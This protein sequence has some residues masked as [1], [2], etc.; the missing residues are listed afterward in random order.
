MII[1]VERPMK[2]YI[3]LIVLYVFLFSES[4]T[5]QN[6]GDQISTVEYIEI[7]KEVAIKE[8]HKSKIPASITLAQGILES[9]KGNSDLAKKAN[10]HFGIKCHKEWRGKTFHMDD[11]EK[12]ECFRKYNNAEESYVDHSYFLTTRERYA[13]LFE[14]D[15]ADYKR[16]AH[17]LK[18]AGY[19]TNPKY[20]HIL[21]RIIEENHL[22]MF[23][24][25]Y[26]GKHV[27]TDAKKDTG[28][29]KTEVFSRDPDEFKPILIAKGNRKIYL[30][31]GIKFIQAGKG[32]D[33]RK[34]ADD[35]E[36]LDW[37]IAR[38]N[39][40]KKGDRLKE[41]ETVYIQ[42]KKKKGSKA[43]HLVRPHET[44]HFIS[45]M[46]GIKLKHLYK[47]NNMPYGSSP[48]VGQKLWLRKKK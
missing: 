37:Q 40:M 16:W 43:Y 38:Y 29:E 2:Y 18:K 1:A 48:R 41:K 11:D 45:Q 20:A 13:E 12:N 26:D 39:D 44:M 7:Y 36:M 47:K 19:A 27:L 42:P 31:N 4:I 30:H 5:G 14:L 35:L 34:I 23:D 25:Q 24:K 33:F 32:D 21:I 46:Y 6:G 17:G 9:G 15:I 3:T 10:N 8:M 22:F 28:E